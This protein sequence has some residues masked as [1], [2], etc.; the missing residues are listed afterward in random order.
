MR[1]SE[2]E[3]RKAY[4]TGVRHISRETPLRLPISLPTSPLRDLL[5]LPNAKA[6]IQAIPPQQ[7]F[8]SLKEEGV[9][10]CLEVLPLISQEQFTRICDYDVWPDDRLSL[11]QLFFWLQHCEMAKHGDNFRRFKKLEEEYQLAALIPC[12]RIFDEDEYEKLSDAEQDQL[13]ALPGNAFYYAIE[14]EDPEVYEG[15]QSLIASGLELDIPYLIA[16]LTHA[17]YMPPLESE[18]L[19]SQFRRARLEEDG[20]VTEEE[21][22]ALFQSLSVEAVA[23]KWQVLPTEET[24]EALTL[25]E[26]TWFLEEVLRIGKEKWTPEV[27]ASVMQSFLYLSNATLVACQV[28]LEDRKALEQVFGHV[29]G[30]VNLGLEFLSQGQRDQGARILAAE[31]PRTLFRL[32]FS[33]LRTLQESVIQQMKKNPAFQPLCKYWTL[34]KYGLL[35]RE[36]D[37]HQESLGFLPTE[38]LKGLFNRFPMVAQPTTKEGRIFFEP[39]C[40]LKTWLQLHQLVQTFLPTKGEDA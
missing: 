10:D 6:K 17:A 5:A 33:I 23:K 3:L 38:F 20:F 30:W 35:L 21:S 39:V 12:I 14:C 29:Q 22:Q 34:Q 25:P 9:A 4:D 18:L 19:L 40:S 15:I 7:L 26:N 32:G 31:T 8:F 24:I 16:L 37:L 11:R 28:P 1:L 13:H 27:Y 36:L 2:A